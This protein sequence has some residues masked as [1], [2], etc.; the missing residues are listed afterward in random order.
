MNWKQLLSSNRIGKTTKVDSFRSA[1]EQDYDRIIFS[2]PFRRLQD[3]TQVHPLPEYDFVHTRLTH[4][5]EVS[6]VGRSLGKKVGES[7]LQKHPELR[8]DGFSSY[9][10]GAIVAAAA[11]AHDIGNPPFGHS[12][13]SAISD[14]FNAADKT[15]LFKKHMSSR[16]WADIIDFEG[17]AQGFRLIN[18]TNGLQL[19]NATLAAFTKYPRPSLISNHDKGR[20]SQKKYGYFQS[21]KQEFAELAFEVGLMPFSGEGIWSRHPLAFLVEAADDICYQVIDLEDGCRLELVSYDETVDLLG[22][23]I[24]ENFDRDKLDKYNSDAEKIGVLRAMSIGKLVDE[25]VAVFLANEKTLL[26]GEF[27]KALT[28][29]IPSSEILDKIEQLSITKIYQS[30]KVL[31]K[32]AAGFEVLPGLLE[33]FTTAVYHYYLDKD[34]YTKKL[35]NLIR[36]LPEDI[37]AKMDQSADSFYDLLMITIDFI[38]GMTDTHAISL[39]R[40]IKGIS[41]PI[42]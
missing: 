21:D 30:R 29:L 2:H 32:E 19:T 36:L 1:F 24:G 12:G 42:S 18:Q 25:C 28:G 17:N 8:G 20:K 41:L 6:S 10:F 15:A 22:A 5:L 7:I 3:K 33:S 34:N 39:Y 14:F 40:K 23:I 13:E 16:Q 9:D 31:E 27:D 26:S 35:Q 37:K 4:S 38:S 11:L